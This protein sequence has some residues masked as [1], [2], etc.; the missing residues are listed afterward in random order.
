M[1]P[2]SS[3]Q[4]VSQSSAYEESILKIQISFPSTSSSETSSPR[5]CL[6]ITIPLSQWVSTPC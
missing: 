4:T 5:I 6:P 1:S 3:S 2:F